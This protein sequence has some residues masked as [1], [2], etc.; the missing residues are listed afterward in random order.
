MAYQIPA[1]VKARG[2]RD[3]ISLRALIL[4]LLEDWVAK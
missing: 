1:D 3:G 2:K 4:K